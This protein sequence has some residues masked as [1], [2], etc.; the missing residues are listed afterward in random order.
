MPLTAKQRQSKI[1][2]ALGSDDTVAYDGVPVVKKRRV[3]SY[4]GRQVNC[5]RIMDR[6]IMS[7]ALFDNTRRRAQPSLLS[8][9]LISHTVANLVLL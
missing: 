4:S 6:N 8:T 9:S 1:S 3:T 2:A 5:S 7:S